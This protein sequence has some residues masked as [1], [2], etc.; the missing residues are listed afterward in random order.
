MPAKLKDFSIQY[1]FP[2]K[3]GMFLVCEEL[4]TG[5]EI[6]IPVIYLCHL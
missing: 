5:K 1:Q 3:T 4:I 2:Y 6:P